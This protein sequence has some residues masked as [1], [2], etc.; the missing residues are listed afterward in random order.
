M[1]EFDEA[2]ERDRCYI[3]PFVGE[4]RYARYLRNFLEAVPPAQILVLNFDEWTARPAEAM[5][6]V[7]RFLQLAPFSYDVERAHNTHLARSVHVELQGSSN[8]SEVDG[9][10]VVA[11][12]SYPTHCILHEFAPGPRTQCTA[13]PCT[14]PWVHC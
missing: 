13:T 8:A 2:Q 11:S 3:N 4:G 7:G 10:S 12:L 5:A 6:V 14:F 1:D 9:G